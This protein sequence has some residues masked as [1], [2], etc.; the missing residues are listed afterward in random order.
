[1]KRPF[2]LFILIVIFLLQT[3][4]ATIVKDPYEEFIIDTLPAGAKVTYGNQTCHTPCT[5]D[6][7]RRQQYDVSITKSGYKSLTY[8][9]NGKSWDG[10]L[11]GNIVFLVGAPIGVAVDFITGKAYDYSPSEIKVKLEE[12]Q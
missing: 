6:L 4:C 3:H 11:W 10:W 12:A 8:E 5:L 2:Y 9:L 1:M 7:K